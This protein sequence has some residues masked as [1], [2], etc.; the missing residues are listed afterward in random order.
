MKEVKRICIYPKDIALITGK[1]ERH[2]RRILERI[3]L[4]L[5]KDTHQIVTINEF[6]NYMGVEKREIEKIIN[7]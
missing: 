3:K 4:E 7:I 1:S 2:G 5:Q 6:C